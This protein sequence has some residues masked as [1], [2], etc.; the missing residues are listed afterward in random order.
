MNLRITHT[1]RYSDVLLREVPLELSDREL[2]G[3]AMMSASS[4]FS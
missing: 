2:Q 3:I 1:R 4:S